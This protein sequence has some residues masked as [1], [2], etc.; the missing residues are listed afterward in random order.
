MLY[1]E[2][3]LKIRPLIDTRRLTMQEAF[4]IYGGEFKSIASFRSK[5]WRYKKLYELERKRCESC[6]KY[7]AADSLTMF[8]GQRVCS[9][10][11][12]GPYEAT[13]IPA[14]IASPMNFEG[15]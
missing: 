8:R 11:L 7:F 14:W 1:Y 15:Y 10:C 9:E 5:Y 13:E 6:S 12:N 3:Y 2:T 4:E